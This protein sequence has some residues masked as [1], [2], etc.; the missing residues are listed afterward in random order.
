MSN[1]KY[2]SIT[3]LAQ[4]MGL[5]RVQVFRKIKAKQ[6]PAEKIGNFYV[7]PRDYAASIT[8][9]MTKKDERT[10]KKGVA[11]VIKEYGE[12]IKKLGNT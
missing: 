6:I 4:I 3:D 12:V 2:L 1:N 9:E 7:I 10:I 11:R 8:G 5:S